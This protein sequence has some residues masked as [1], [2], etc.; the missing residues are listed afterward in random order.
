MQFIYKQIF[1]LTFEVIAWALNHPALFLLFFS[2]SYTRIETF[3]FLFPNQTWLSPSISTILI[4]MCT[5]TWIDTDTIYIFLKR[6]IYI[7]VNIIVLAMA[8]KWTTSSFISWRRWLLSNRGHQRHSS[9]PAQAYR[10]P[11]H[12]E[13]WCLILPMLVRFP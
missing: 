3:R 11:F 9:M 12:R 2:T 5:H 7:Q 6:Y 4:R 10:N 1:L 13:Y 8:E